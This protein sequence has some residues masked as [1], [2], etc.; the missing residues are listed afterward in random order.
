MITDELVKMSSKGQLVVP[1]SIRKK[2][3][4]NEGDRFIAVDTVQ[5]VIFKKV[6]IPDIKIR[7]EKLHEEMSAHA[8]KYHITQKDVDGAVKWARKSKSG[9]R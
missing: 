7:L 1:Y 3:K 6:N 9:S 4:L 8:R 2:E 5:G